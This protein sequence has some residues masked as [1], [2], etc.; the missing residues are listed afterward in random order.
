MEVLVISGGAYLDSKAAEARAIGEDYDFT[1]NGIHFVGASSVDDLTG[2]ISGSGTIQGTLAGTDT[3]ADGTVVDLTHSFSMWLSFTQTVAGSITPPGEPTYGIDRTWEGTFNG[4]VAAFTDETELT[5]DGV[6]VFRNS[7]EM[8]VDVTGEDFVLTQDGTSEARKSD[9]SGAGV[10]VVFDQVSYYLDD[11]FQPY[12]TAGTISVE[13]Y[14]G[15]TAE[16]TVQPDG[17]MQGDLVRSGGC[18]GW[19]AHAGGVAPLLRRSRLATCRT[20]EAKSPGQSG[21]GFFM[22]SFPLV[23]ALKGCKGRTLAPSVFKGL[24]VQ[25]LGPCTLWFREQV[26][27]TRGRRLASARRRGGSETRPAFSRALSEGCRVT[28]VWRPAQPFSRAL[29]ERVQG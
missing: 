13:S 20:S 3:P 16:L 10:E 29:S 5:Y 27:E 23:S 28:V 9:D 14:D 19:H 18:A 8:T 21:S 6:W 15:Y 22:A 1:V 11:D 17:T 25:G 24:M 4:S 12:Y 26:P 2:A 7:L